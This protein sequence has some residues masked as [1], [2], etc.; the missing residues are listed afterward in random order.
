ME[1][2]TPYP[3]SPA[4][5]P[6]GEGGFVGTKQKGRAMWCRTF[7]SSDVAGSEKLLHFKDSEIS[8][9]TRD[10]IPTI[11]KNWRKQVNLSAFA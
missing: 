3:L 6:T 4:P 10:N 2:F 9:N 1:C 5:V 8:K 7:R 11:L